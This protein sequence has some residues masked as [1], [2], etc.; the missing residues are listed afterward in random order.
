M[1]LKTLKCVTGSVYNTHPIFSEDTEALQ[2][3][4]YYDEIELC[5]PLGSSTKIHKL[6]CLFFTLGNV[7]PKFR[8]QLKSI[9]VAAIGSNVVIRRHG[10]NLFLEPFVESMKTLS[11]NGLKVLFKGECRVFKV[12]LL[13]I[14]ADTLA[15]HALGGF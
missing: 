1:V 2:I 7:H 13:A 11:K 12:G 9:F 3:I 10:L 6:G 5:N 4:A 14:L 15:A 8:S